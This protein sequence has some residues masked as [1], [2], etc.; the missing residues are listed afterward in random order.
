MKCKN[1]NNEVINNQGFCNVCGSKIEV[2]INLSDVDKTSMNSQ[3]I[4]NYDFDFSDQ[5]RSN[6]PNPNNITVRQTQMP[7]QAPSQQIDQ[8]VQVQNNPQQIEQPV[9]VQQV[10]PQQI[11]QPVQVQNNPQQIEQPVQVQNNPQQ[12]IN[13]NNQY[14][15]LG[16]NDHKHSH[17]PIIIICILSILVGGGYFVYNT[18]FYDSL[19]KPNIENTGNT[20]NEKEDIPV[21]E[22]KEETKEDEK[23]E[24]KEENKETSTE[25][26]GNLTVPVN[27]ISYS[28]VTLEIP[29]TLLYRYEEEETLVIY[30]ENEEWAAAFAVSEGDYYT[31]KNKKAELAKEIEN[32]G[33]TIKN[34]GVK[35]YGGTEWLTFETEYNSVNILAVYV[36]AKSNRYGAFTIQTLDNTYN[37]NLLR[38]LAPVVQS[39]K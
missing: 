26:S 16:R 1:C 19:E 38:T 13:N 14:S 10:I 33:L 24:N 35:F 29:T 4:V 5:I 15:V 34:Y 23:T 28:G 2:E 37:Y 27:K 39:I 6:T 11:E 18:F 20:N 22:D 3:G 8:P 7:V 9:Q 17:A 21:E 12:N 31:L 32:T 36:N 30:P 25:S